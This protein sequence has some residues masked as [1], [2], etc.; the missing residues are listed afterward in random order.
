MV[1]LDDDGQR[2]TLDLHGAAVG[3]AVEIAEATI[4]EAA[5]HGRQTVRIVHGASTAERGEGR[6]IRSALREAVEAGDFDRHVTTYVFD[7]GSMLLGLA[8]SP[9]P[10]G[11]RIRLVDVW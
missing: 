2:I 8:P 7:D 10:V 4:V 5:R 11:T 6:T 1:R 9:R 3:R